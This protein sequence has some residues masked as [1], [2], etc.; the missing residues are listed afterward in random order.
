MHYYINE[1]EATHTMLIIAV[2]SNTEIKRK[3][4]IR[5]VIGV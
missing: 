3:K 4:K 5:R 2:L 1:V